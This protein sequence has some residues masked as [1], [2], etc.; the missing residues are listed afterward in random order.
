MSTPYLA[1]EQ[2]PDFTSPAM[3]SRKSASTP[4][5]SHKHTPPAQIEQTTASSHKHGVHHT[6]S[7][8]F[9][10]RSPRNGEK[11]RRAI[12]RITKTNASLGRS[13]GI[14]GP[15]ANGMPGKHTRNASSS[16]S[17]NPS[18]GRIK[19]KLQRGNTHVGR[20]QTRISS[21]HCHLQSLELP[22]RQL[23]I[24]NAISTID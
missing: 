20:L 11:A 3:S 12:A 10:Q 14:D 6:Q 1:L 8:K 5:T 21:T 9:W 19:S 7:R 16:S 22:H 13:E 2:T 24:K 17:R 18:S 4:S 23:P 15:C